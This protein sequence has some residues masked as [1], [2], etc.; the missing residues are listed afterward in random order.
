VVF[1]DLAVPGDTSANV[2][3]LAIGPSGV[4][5]IDS[6]QWTGSV[7]Q[8]SDGLVWHN[9]YPL[10]R[11]LETVRWEAQ[12]VGRLLGTRIHPLLCVHGA[13]VHGDG[14]AAQGVAIMPAHLLRSALGYDQVL[15]DADVPRAPKRL[16]GLRRPQPP[17]LAQ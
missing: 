11:T 16:P 5:V 7:Q 17:R 3:H 8:G 10:D 4:F 6:E 2:D 15:S 1:H 14:L 12:Q 9:H 13:H